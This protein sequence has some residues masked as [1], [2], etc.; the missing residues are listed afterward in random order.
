M[1]R[2]LLTLNLITALLSTGLGLAPA[3]ALPIRESQDFDQAFKQQFLRFDDNPMTFEGTVQDSDVSDIL[4]IA[5]KS[6]ITTMNIDFNTSNAA[7]SI[8]EDVN[9]NGQIDAGD[10]TVVQ[11]TTRSFTKPI[12]VSAAKTFLVEVVKRN[13]GSA[14]SLTIR[15]AQLRLQARFLQAKV[16]RMR[17]LSEFD[18]VG[19]ADFGVSLS[20]NGAPLQTKKV[21]GSDSPTF[22]FGVRQEI[23]INQESVEVEIYAFESDPASTVNEPD[24][25]PD[26]NDRDLRLHYFPRTGEIF[27]PGNRR[28]GF[29]NQ[30]ITLQGDANKHKASITF[31][32]SHSDV[33]F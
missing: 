1:K 19:S 23:P 28:L 9:N 5:A 22:N 7:Y 33:V 14:Y 21:N 3:H 16:V 4:K 12:R 25:S 13:A 6:G 27:G 2:Q 20:L 18:L 26:P 10:R 11:Q 15:G 24:I 31:E 8:V 17:A 29:A 32:I 30:P